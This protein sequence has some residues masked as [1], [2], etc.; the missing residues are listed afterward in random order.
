MPHRSLLLILPV[1][2]SCLLPINA[3]AEALW[4]EFRGPTAQ[5]HSAARGLPTEW[6]PQKNIVW[7]TELPG[8]AWSSP[9]VANGRIIL[10]NAIPLA[11]GDESK[12]VSLRVFTADAATGTAGWDT[13]VFQVTDEAALKMHRKNSQ[14]SP[15]VIYEAGR[16]YAH[17]GHHGTACLD[18]KG[19]ILW[20]NRE[21]NLKSKHG[22]GGS[23]VIVDDLLIFDNDS[24]EAPGVVALDKSTGKTR[25]RVKRPA[26]EAKSKFS[27]STPLVI[28][29]NGQKQVISP[30]SGIVQAL[31]P[32]DGA[33]IWHVL[34]ASG[35]SVVPRPVYAHGMVF[36]SSGFNKAVGYAIR[37][38]G[39]GDVTGTHVAWS[40]DK[41]VPLNP[42]MLVVG[43]ELYMLDDGG[44]LSC[45]DARSGAQHYQERL[46]GP[47]SASL[48]FA[49]GRIYAIDEL[50]KSAVVAPGK[51]LQV[52]ATSELGEKT[53]ASMAVCGNDLL[54]RTEKALYRV[55]KKGA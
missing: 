12:G 49:D 34:Y 47:C 33:E 3:R 18:E 31:N 46:V 22:T 41:H 7:R 45:M 17:F 1:A 10:T 38:D 11:G 14:A 23:P 2:A 19:A 44:F 55:G 25:W 30:G 52:L 42:S 48:L 36:L 24:D 35:Y 13:E 16:I 54:I 50:G 26:T 9:V 21:N 4:P 43:D 29:V 53:L 40:T 51:T 28:E 15:S 39:R 20:T 8:H 6:S 27:F 32:K 5:G 37:A